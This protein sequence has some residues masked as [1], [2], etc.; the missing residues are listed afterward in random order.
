MATSSVQIRALFSGILGIA[1]VVAP[2]ALALETSP[3]AAASKSAPANKPMLTRSPR[4][5]P[6]PQA[7]F[8]VNTTNDTHDASP[9][10]NPVC[11]DASNKCSLRAAVEE[12]NAYGGTVSITVPPGTYTL[13]QA[14]GFGTIVAQ[15]PAG[16]QIV[17][18]APGVSITN[19]A[20]ATAILATGH[21]PSTNIG[22]FLALANVTITGSHGGGLLV[23]DDN[24]TVTANSVAFSN[25][26]ITGS[27]GAVVNEGQFWATGS[28]F[29]GNS[30]TDKGGAVWDDL[31][32]A[33]LSADTFGNN[34]AVSEGGALQNNDGPVAVDNSNFTGNSVHNATGEADGGA[35]FAGEEMEF[36]GDNFSGNSAV[37]TGG[38]DAVGGAVYDSYGL[39]AVTNSSFTGNSSV[40]DPTSGGG[41]GGAFYDDSSLTITGSIFSGNRAVN[42]SGGGLYED[43]EGLVLEGDSITGN[44]AT[45]GD[46]TNTDEGFG[47]GA[48]CGDICNI[49]ATT[50]SGNSASQGGGGFANDD[51]VII[52]S[53]LISGNTAHLGAGI[54]GS[55]NWQAT[56]VAI[57]DNTTTGA[58]DSGGGVYLKATSAGLSGANRV[59]FIGVTV[60][61]NVSDTGAGFALDG[62]TGGGLLGVG[63]GTLSNS[64]VAGNRTPAGLEADCAVVNASSN[65]LPLGSAGG[66]V[67]GDATCGFK[68]SS[69]RQGAGAQG[70]WMTA[71][72]GGIFNYNG[73]FFGSMGGKVLNKPVVGMAHTPGN[74]GYWEVASDGGIFSFGD[75]GFFG[76]MGGKPA[77][78]A[79]RRHRRHTGR[80]RLLGGRVR[81]RHLQLRRRRILR[82]HGRQ[83]AQRAG[84]RHR[85]DTGRTRVLGGRV[86]RRH[87]RLRR[88]RI[89]RF[90]G[91]QAAQQADRGDRPRHRRQRLPRGGQRRGRLR[92][93]AVG[94]LLRLGREPAPQRPGRRHRGRSG[95]AGILDLR[96]RRWGLQL[97][98][99][100]PVQGFGRLAPPQQAGGGRRSDL[101]RHAA[102]RH[103]STPVGTVPF[104]LVRYISRRTPE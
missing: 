85:R 16:V 87:L 41:L 21:A 45:G 38:N 23:A 62:T 27:G 82:F 4:T 72:D 93:R 88:R 34:S 83:A 42:G 17:G 24:D 60:A 28:T 13:S 77:Q 78:R 31:G 51:S 68:T 49:D 55:W 99:R 102:S 40:S 64:T 69:D 9:G 25:N 5:F 52:T 95:H 29:T 11:A 37:G 54:W 12:A 8:A 73:G 7:T 32:S 57:V 75:A 58:G 100:C 71:A 86:G 30:S 1:L 47:G 67:V 53:S 97:R 46:G 101:S 84:R 98:D 81:R 103:C 43:D 3:A 15:D 90:H 35:V 79:G 14:A 89:L 19:S 59:D 18:T 44:S 22:A 56:S 48:F 94:R 63:G 26:S 91:W 92:L 74:Q 50:V 61:G 76:S 96:H 20:A 10:A 66:N 33:R 39:N 80:R 65:A 36:T 2:L 104:T 6:P 70:Y